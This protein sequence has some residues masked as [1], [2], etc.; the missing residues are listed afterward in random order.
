MTRKNDTWTYIISKNVQTGDTN[1]SNGIL[2]I[3]LGDILNWSWIWLITISNF[4]E[5]LTYCYR[6]LSNRLNQA[7]V[8]SP[9]KTH[10]QIFFLFSLKNLSFVEYSPLIGGEMSSLIGSNGWVRVSQLHSQ[11]G[12]ALNRSKRP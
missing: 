4:Y 6:N 2:A 1:S 7:L 8:R 10:F 9:K 11:R 5:S 12:N 3:G